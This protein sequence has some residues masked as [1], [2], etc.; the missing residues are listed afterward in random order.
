MLSEPHYQT[1]TIH[2]N[3]NSN[4]NLDTDLDS[5][6]DLDIELYLDYDSPT[7]IISNLTISVFLIIYLLTI[8]QI[9]REFDQQQVFNVFLY[10]SFISFIFIMICVFM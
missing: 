8:H 6:T 10:T 7:R 5:D 3:S 9:Q 1:I 4:S 2:S